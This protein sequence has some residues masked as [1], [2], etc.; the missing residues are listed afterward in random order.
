[1][2][3]AFHTPKN[4]IENPKISLK[5]NIAIVQKARV[6]TFLAGSFTIET[7]LVFPVVLY[8]LVLILLF[9]QAM[10]VSQVVKKT[11]NY[12][13]TKTAIMAGSME[14]NMLIPYA[15]GIFQKE[16]S[17][18]KSIEKNIKGGRFG[19]SFHDSVMDDSYV[20]FVATYR[21]NMPIRY[22]GTKE[23]YVMQRCRIHKWIGYQEKEQNDSTM[24]LVFVTHTGSVYHNSRECTHIKLSVHTVIGMPNQ[25]NGKKYAPCELCVKGTIKGNTWYITDEGRK[26]HL[27]INCSGLKR[28]V[29]MIDK[30]QAEKEGRAL[31][32]RC[33]NTKSK[34]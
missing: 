25:W 27:R 13:C 23:L 29:Y 8:S 7:A 15:V 28:M 10:S 9:F 21:L 20:D 12:A 14:E 24:N 32:S 1:V 33:L 16:L 2:P 34:E 26:Y 17:V 18:S 22:F 31:C 11:L 5:N 19:I 4:I 30:L 6:N 3:F